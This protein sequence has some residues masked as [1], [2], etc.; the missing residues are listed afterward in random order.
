MPSCDATARGRRIVAS[1]HDDADAGGLEGRDRSWC[2]V[3]DRIGPTPTRVGRRASPPT[4]RHS[5]REHKLHPIGETL[6]DQHVQIGQMTAHFERRHGNG[7]RTPDP[8]AARHVNELRARPALRLHLDRLQCHPA[9][10][11][12]PRAHPPDPGCIGQV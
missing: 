1:E 4:A 9:D 2:G 6:P 7:E 11:T 10:W 8:E 12:G 5:G 3:L